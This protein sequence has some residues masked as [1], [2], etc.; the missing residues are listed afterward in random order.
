MSKLKSHARLNP[1]KN[2]S[3]EK[4]TNSTESKDFLLA[5]IKFIPV[6]IFSHPY[7]IFFDN[8]P[9]ATHTLLLQPIRQCIPY[10]GLTGTCRN[11]GYTFAT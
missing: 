10:V 4:Y 9:P 5:K 3:P 6:K 11:L 8:P 1:R 2:K 7:S